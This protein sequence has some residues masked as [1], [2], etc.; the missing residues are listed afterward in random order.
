MNTA[1]EMAVEALRKTTAQIINS[2]PKSREELESLFIKVY[3][4]T[5]MIESFSPISFA[6]PFIY[7]VEKA[8]GKKG[9]LIFQHNP[10]FYYSFEEE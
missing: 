3:D 8:T 5:E 9:T 10:R 1:E 6:A 2:N 7:V 4:T